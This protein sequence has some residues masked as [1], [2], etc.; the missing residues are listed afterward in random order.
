MWAAFVRQFAAYALTRRGKKLF[1]F[2]GA[3]LLC[4]ATTLLIDMQLYASA[5]FTGL[6]ALAAVVSFAVHHVKLKRKQRERLARLA[7]E[8]IRRAER[9]KARAERI[10]RSKAAFAGA[11]GSAAVAASDALGGA[12]RFVADGFAEMAQEAADAYRETKETAGRAASAGASA[13][14]DGVAS[15]TQAA[16]EALAR[17]VSFMRRA[18][19]SR[20]AP[21]A[22]AEQR[23]G[24]HAIPRIA[25]R[26]DVN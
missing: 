16:R 10:A 22:L 12:A 7:E 20:A 23:L 21:A 24:P 2:L 18:S 15:L 26:P 9:A 6:L 3:M 13:V 14:T 5:G 11:F 8:A 1:A 4:F 19:L 17:V 25:L